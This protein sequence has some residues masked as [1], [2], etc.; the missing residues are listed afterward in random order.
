MA[1]K[2]GRLGADSLGEIVSAASDAPAGITGPE[3]APSL[4][5]AR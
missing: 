2:P 3:M 1:P 4:E 5:R